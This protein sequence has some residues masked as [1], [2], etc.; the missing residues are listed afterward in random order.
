MLHSVT[1]F[2]EPVLVSLTSNTVTE[3]SE[4]EF[5]ERSSELLVVKLKASLEKSAPLIMSGG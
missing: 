2:S 1:Y 3:T 5:T 4:A